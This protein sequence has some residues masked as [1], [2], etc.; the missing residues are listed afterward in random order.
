MKNHFDIHKKDEYFIKN[1]EAFEKMVQNINNMKNMVL[2]YDSDNNFIFKKDKTN[3]NKIINLN[4]TNSCTDINLS[5][6]ISSIEEQKQ[7]S[8]NNINDKNFKKDKKNNYISKDDNNIL[9]FD[10]SDDSLY[11]IKNNKE[12]EK[13]ISNEIEKEIVDSEDNL[14][15]KF[16]IYPLDNKFNLVK[17]EDNNNFNSNDMNIEDKYFS[18]QIFREIPEKESISSNLK[19]N[20]INLFYLKEKENIDDENIDCYSKITNQFFQSYQYQTQINI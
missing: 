9:N 4:S 18:F 11:F 12:K 19:N 20:D 17:K 15:I 1:K 10:D 13:N 16:P 3:N 2:N 14:D 7:E 8:C 5:L 6:P